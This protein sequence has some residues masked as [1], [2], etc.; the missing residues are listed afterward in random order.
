MKLVFIESLPYEATTWVLKAPTCRVANYQQALEEAKKRNI[1]ALGFHIDSRQ[2]VIQFELAKKK[3]RA[4]QILK[5]ILCAGGGVSEDCVES[6]HVMDRFHAETLGLV[7]EYRVDGFIDLVVEQ[8]EDESSDELEEVDAQ[9]TASTALVQVIPEIFSLSVYVPRR[10]LV[11]SFNR[12]QMTDTPEFTQGR[13][14][15]RDAEGRQTLT[16]EALSQMF[17]R[18]MEHCEGMQ[19][20]ARGLAR[21]RDVLDDFVWITDRPEFLNVYVKGSMCENRRVEWIKWRAAQKGVELTPV[22]FMFFFKQV[23]NTISSHASLLVAYKRAMKILMPEGFEFKNLSKDMQTEINDINE[24]KNTSYCRV[25]A[26]VL[27]KTMDSEFCSKKCRQTLCRWCGTTKVEREVEDYE[28]TSSQRNRHGSIE[29][30]WA[31]AGPHMCRK[32]VEGWLKEFA[33]PTQTYVDFQRYSSRDR[34][35]CCKR[36]RGS[37][38]ITNTPPWC[39]PCLDEKRYSGML[40]EYGMAI[41]AGKRTWHHAEAAF[42]LVQT[43]IALP[44]VMK[45]EL[46]CDTCNPIKRRRVS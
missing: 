19:D 28:A 41:R 27:M 10:I 21:K 39:Q 23:Y 43:V 46:Y 9:P 37:K 44:R 40:R 18:N 22:S 14:A 15:F 12:A 30:L 33:D 31:M 13:A 17:P 20:A 8:D 1:V 32:D 45:I 24:G 42:R 4:V 38:V 36:I 2:I 29:A 35:N 5:L 3:Q 34:V 16:E 6:L 11:P 26:A 7:P 25:C